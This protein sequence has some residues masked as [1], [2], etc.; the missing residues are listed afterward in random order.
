[1]LVGVGCSKSL[2][3]EEEKVVGSYE[4]DGIVSSLIFREDKVVEIKGGPGSDAET[5][6]WNAAGVEVVVTTIEENES[7]EVRFYR[8]DKNGD[9]TLVAFGAET[10]G[11]VKRIDLAKADFIFFK[12]RKKTNEKLN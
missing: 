10:K 1:M 6:R 2:T 7:D 4:S 12:K 3:E 9:L 11:E 5:G 8:I